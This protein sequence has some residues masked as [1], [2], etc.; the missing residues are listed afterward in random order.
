MPAKT[1][2]HTRNKK[3]PERAAVFGTKVSPVKRLGRKLFSS[4]AP[5]VHAAYFVQ[6]PSASPMSARW[7]LLSIIREL[8]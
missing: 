2:G 5:K 8:R 6:P 7:E 4:Q 1:E 3:K